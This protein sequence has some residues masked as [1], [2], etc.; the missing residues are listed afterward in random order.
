MKT[1]WQVSD[2][3]REI[4]MCSNEVEFLD[5]RDEWQH[6][7]IIAT[8]ERIVFGG[9]CN[10][11]FIESG[12]IVRGEFETLDETLQEMLADLETYY[13]DGAQYVSRIVCNDRM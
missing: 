4:E 7:H 12:Y 9:C 8:P 1:Q 10:A 3:S 13:N 5:A 2:I 11:G 6:F